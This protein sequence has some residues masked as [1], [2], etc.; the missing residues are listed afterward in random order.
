MTV[1]TF[2]DNLKSSS[3][4]DPFKESLASLPDIEQS[5]FDA[6]GEL[7][8]SIALGDMDKDVRGEA[9]KILKTRGNEVVKK[10][11]K[12][13]SARNYSTTAGRKKLQ[14]DLVDLEAIEGFD[15]AVFAKYLYVRN[16]SVRDG[17]DYF[18]QH[19]TREAFREYFQYDRVAPDGKIEIGMAAK[20]PGTAVES[21]F[22]VLPSIEEQVFVIE[23]NS[24]DPVDVDFS[25]LGLPN[26][27]KLS[28]KLPLKQFP[29]GLF[30]LAHLRQLFVFSDLE[31]IPEGLSRMS[32]LKNLGLGCPI[33]RLPDDFAELRG[34]S[35]LNIDDS[36]LISLPSYLGEFK[37]LT[38]MYLRN[39]A[40]LTDVP[41]SLLELP[42]L[43]DGCKEY[44]RE[45]YFSQT[46]YEKVY[47]RLDYFVAHFKTIPAV[48]EVIEAYEKRRDCSRLG[49]LILAT[50]RCYYDDEHGLS[51][52]DFYRL[53]IE[54][55]APKSLREANR[56]IGTTRFI[57]HRATDAELDAL[58]ALLEDAIGFDEGAFIDFVKAMV[59]AVR[60]EYPFDKS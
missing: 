25:T 18:F 27:Y 43:S 17:L 8:M 60:E 12:L 42:R 24:K 1:R 16:F 46:E 59:V 20:S 29:K 9:K 45:T 50:S 23:I 28:L 40:L 58:R 22:D 33:R 11:L 55:T 14:A 57:D 41:S 34:L 15:V 30:G 37:D 44:L 53:Q 5:A 54:Q 35:S 2:K 26:L 51:S 38:S 13:K 39:N 56:K 48:Q 4:V 7:L 36:K 3:W 52:N 31:E 6:L 21:L 49:E 10:A 19:A 47:N 32:A